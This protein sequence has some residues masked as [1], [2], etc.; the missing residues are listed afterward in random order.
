MEFKSGFWIVA[1]FGVF[2]N[3]S[4]SQT[5]NLP[6][7][8]FGQEQLPWCWAATDQMIRWHY[9]RI[10]FPQCEIAASNL[11]HPCCSNLTNCMKFG[12][13]QIPSSGRYN[14]QSMVG[15]AIAYSTIKVNVNESKPWIY[16]YQLNGG[17][18]HL[19]VGAGYSTDG[20]SIKNVL[21]IDPMPV[22]V[23]TCR[24]IT[25]NE[26]KGGTGYAYKVNFQHYD[27]SLK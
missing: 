13:T 12:N 16:A 23:G 10:Q 14:L 21:I 22:G 27:L 17:G 6:V 24:W 15:T 4:Q 5:V 9:E 11:G 1:F 26:Y 18:G 19:M 8:I 3:H 25:Y 20:A 2:L 7:P